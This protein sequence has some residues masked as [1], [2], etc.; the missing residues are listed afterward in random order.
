MSKEWAIGSL[1][2]VFV[3]ALLSLEYCLK[4]PDFLLESFPEGFIQD[5]SNLRDYKA[6]IKPVGR[7][8]KVPKTHQ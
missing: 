8:E 4:F 6:M 2:A 5:L 1:S 3:L 7:V